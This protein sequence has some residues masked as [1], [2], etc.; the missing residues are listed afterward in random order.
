MRAYLFWA[1]RDWLDPKNGFNPALPPDDLLVE[2]ACDIHWSFLSNG[3]IIIEKKEEIKKRIK[4]SPDRFDA[5]ANTFYPHDY[6]YA[7]DEKLLNNML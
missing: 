7:N 4:R 6:D 2:E 1:V 5:L 3:S